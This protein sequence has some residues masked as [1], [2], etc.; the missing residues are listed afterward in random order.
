MKKSFRKQFK[1]FFF[2][3]YDLTQSK[4]KAEYEAQGLKVVCSVKQKNRTL[5]IIVDADK[6]LHLIQAKSAEIAV[7]KIIRAE[8]YR[9]EE[10]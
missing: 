2:A 1:E 7:D 8:M 9:R 4:V 5:W 6:S 10:K 3:L